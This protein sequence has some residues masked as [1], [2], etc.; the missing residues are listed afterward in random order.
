[1]FASPTLE[2]NNGLWKLNHVANVLAQWI[3]QDMDGKADD[4]KT[5]LALQ[6]KLKNHKHGF[7]SQ[8]AIIM[9]HSDQDK[10]VCCWQSFLFPCFPWFLSF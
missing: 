4:A 6:G 10:E 9:F 1:M 3:D 5:I 7:Y 2:K 8:G